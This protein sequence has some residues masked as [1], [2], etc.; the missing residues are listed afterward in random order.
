MDGMTC[1]ACDGTHCR[2]MP[3][4]DGLE[5][6]PCPVCQPWRRGFPGEYVTRGGR[7]IWII[8][9]AAPGVAA[10]WVGWPARETL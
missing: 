2:E 4:A 6:Y 7:R 8:E 5:P 10:R 9:P 1:P 3:T